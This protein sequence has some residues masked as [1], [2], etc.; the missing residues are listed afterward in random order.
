LR[1]VIYGAGAIGATIGG[2]LFE[3]GHDVVLIARGAHLGALQREGLRLCDPD[4]SRTI[5]IPSVAH[6]DAVEW[7]SD[8][9]V[10]LGVKT[11]D[12]AAAVE[13]LAAN[14][15]P[16]VAV[17]CAQ[18][19]VENER[20][21][22]R[23]FAAVYGMCVMMPTSHVDPGVVHAYLAP[24]M[25]VLDVGRYPRGVDDRAEAVAADLSAAGFD[26]RPSPDVMRWKY[27]KL[28]VNLGN[29]LTAAC[30]PAAREGDL[31][32][33]A[34]AEAVACFA[35]AGIDVSTDEE[36]A[37]HR[38]ALAPQRPVEGRPWPG[39]SSWQSLARSTGRIETDYLNGE[40]VLLGRLHRVATPV[41]A[42]LQRVAVDLARRGAP[43]GSV[44]LAEVERLLG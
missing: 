36:E 32:H 40:I 5:R 7:R 22:L 39:G 9:A 11:Q 4:R 1:Y 26:G 16:S 8:D 12:T 44:P 21:A 28:L 18:N 31:H 15:P 13:A 27:Q 42:V 24:P 30:G 34:R 25:G 14:A 2:Q 20:L 17:I 37:E 43:P 41:N 33:R 35:A 23:Q 6:P 19:G 29:A 3:H 10:V 38:S